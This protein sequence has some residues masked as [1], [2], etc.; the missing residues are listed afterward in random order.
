[1][2]EG[3]TRAT[4]G[5]RGGAFTEVEEVCSPWTR[6]RGRNFIL[7]NSNCVAVIGL[8]DQGR[9][10]QLALLCCLG[11]WL[12]SGS[13]QIAR[14]WVTQLTRFGGCCTAISARKE[15]S[16]PTLFLFRLGPTADFPPTSRSSADDTP[17]ANPRLTVWFSP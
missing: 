17:N 7:G 11:V 16:E 2:T 3:W 13:T 8:V 12:A 15:G 6:S 10:L 5:W 1:M 14:T 4:G 9:Y